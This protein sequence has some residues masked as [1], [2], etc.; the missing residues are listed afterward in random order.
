MGHTDLP[1]ENVY[2]TVGTKV[3][4]CTVCGEIK[5]LEE[6][7]KDK[8]RKD[9]CRA[10]CKDCRHS[11][12]YKYKKKGRESKYGL[13]RAELARLKRKQE[14]KCLICGSI[15]YLVIDHSH[16]HGHVRGLLCSKC[17]KGLGHFIDS[18]RR[19]WNSMVYIVKREILPSFLRKSDSFILDFKK[20]F[21]SL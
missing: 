13:S 2:A 14:K 20:K 3:K 17:N 9:G 1:T 5:P 19:L 18:P 16:K 10:R 7:H 11:V 15:E 21:V 12:E 6:F 4:R 8:R